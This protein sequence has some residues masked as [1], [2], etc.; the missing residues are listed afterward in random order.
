MGSTWIPVSLVRRGDMILEE[1]RLVLVVGLEEI[2]GGTT[3][4][5][6]L[7]GGGTHIILRR[8]GTYVYGRKVAEL[9]VGR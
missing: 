2:D 4:I 7:A 5:T 8:M 6:V 9:V 3:R 1:D